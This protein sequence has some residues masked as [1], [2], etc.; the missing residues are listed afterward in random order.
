MCRNLGTTSKTQDSGSILIDNQIN[1]F[2]GTFL[3][4]TGGAVRETDSTFKVFRVDPVIN[5]SGQAGGLTL[6]GSGGK[7]GL[8]GT[9]TFVGGVVVN[10]GH[11]LSISRDQ[12]LGA[13]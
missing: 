7:T 8:E 9:N 6:Q 12:N 4:G 3:I 10:S 11:T 5:V 13:W 1:T 2:E